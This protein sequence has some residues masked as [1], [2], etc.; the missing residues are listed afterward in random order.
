MAKFGSKSRISIT[1]ILIII[2][3]HGTAFNGFQIPVHYWKTV[4]KS[5]KTLNQYEKS[6]TWQ[7]TLVP[8]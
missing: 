8:F 4:E 3:G 6:S 1:A 5:K 2:E 7:N